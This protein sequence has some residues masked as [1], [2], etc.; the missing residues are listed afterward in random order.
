MRKQTRRDSCPLSM[1]L[2][3][4]EEHSLRYAD[5]MRNE[6]IDPTS[7]I[8]RNVPTDD[9]EQL[10]SALERISVRN[11]FRHTPYPP[12]RPVSISYPASVYSSNQNSQHTLNQTATRRRKKSSMIGSSHHSKSIR[13]TN[14][15][16]DLNKL[17]KKRGSELF[18]SIPTVDYI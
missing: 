17:G 9:E 5:L 11:K 4:F 10:V 12:K 16:P 2:P 14:S 3:L 18:H 6:E 8:P 7:S 15:L 13:R 1:D